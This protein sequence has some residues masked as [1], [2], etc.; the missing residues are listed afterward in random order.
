MLTVSTVLWHFLQLQMILTK[1]HMLGKST[2]KK[3]DTFYL[4]S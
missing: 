4:I 2:K 3:F 1:A